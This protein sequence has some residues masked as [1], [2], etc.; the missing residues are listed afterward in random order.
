MF[1]VPSLTSLILLSCDLQYHWSTIE[2]EEDGVE[3]GTE[4]IFD[5]LY[6]L[7]LLQVLVIDDCRLPVDLD[8]DDEFTPPKKPL[9]FPHL[10]KLTLHGNVRMV[11]RL[12]DN[13]VVP[14]STSLNLWYYHVR[15][16]AVHDPVIDMAKA[17]SFFTRHFNAA[18]ANG[19]FYSHTDMMYDSGADSRS[20]DPL[21]RVTFE[22]RDPK[23]TGATPLPEQTTI[24]H[25]WTKE[26]DIFI[27]E[28]C[29]FAESFHKTIPCDTESASIHT[30]QLGTFHFHHPF[31][32]YANWYDGIL[33]M[34]QVKSLRLT[35]N[36]IDV[37]ALLLRST[38]Q[39]PTLNSLELEDCHLD[40]HEQEIDELLQQRPA[41][42]IYTTDCTGVE[43]AR[44]RFEVKFKDRIHWD[45]SSSTQA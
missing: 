22:Y 24:K 14:P 38:Q 10:R 30:S 32:A 12:L 18:A 1:L 26:L 6:H 33:K 28:Y 39:I 23:Q 35:N 44:L 8:S 9:A 19:A 4:T 16:V 13:M 37:C 17:V 40:G 2:D 43:G 11:T 25:L 5:A 34:S 3:A 29:D 15:D 41:L 7:P 36:A 27:H 45:R 21:R 20:D 42:N 31:I